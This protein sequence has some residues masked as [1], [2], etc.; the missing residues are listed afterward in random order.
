[1]RIAEREFHGV[2]GQYVLDAKW[3][4]D[5]FLADGSLYLASNLR[6]AV[7][8]LREDQQNDLAF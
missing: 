3:N 2:G 5:L 6:R 7:G 1:M 8:S 4:D